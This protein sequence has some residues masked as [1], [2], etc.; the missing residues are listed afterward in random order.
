M[1]PEASRALAQFCADQYF[2]FDPRAWKRRSQYDHHAS[3]LAA[4]YLCATDWYGH[5]SELALIAAEVQALQ[6]APEGVA[7]PDQPGFDADQFAAMVRSEI[8]H[9]RTPPAPIRTAHEHGSA[10]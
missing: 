10:A 2:A 9:R 6:G 4:A 7:H 1:N 3:T 5:E 8:A